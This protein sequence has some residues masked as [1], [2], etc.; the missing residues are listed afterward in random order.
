MSALEKK[1]KV[2]QVSSASYIP[3]ALN[4]RCRSTVGGEVARVL[5]FVDLTVIVRD[6]GDTEGLEML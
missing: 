4:A 3:L 1:L 6:S 5:S 2:W